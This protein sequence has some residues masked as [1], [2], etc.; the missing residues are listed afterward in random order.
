M[1]LCCQIVRQRRVQQGFQKQ[2]RPTILQQ[3]LGLM[4]QHRA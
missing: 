4:L 2:L 3:S 1:V